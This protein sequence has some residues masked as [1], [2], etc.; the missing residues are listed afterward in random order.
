MIEFPNSTHSKHCNTFTLEFPIIWVSKIPN[1]SLRR[2]PFNICWFPQTG[3]CGPPLIVVTSN[4]STTLFMLLSLK[5][6]K[7]DNYNHG[8]MLFIPYFHNLILH[9]LL[10]FCVGKGSFFPFC[11][12]EYLVTKSIKTQQNKQQ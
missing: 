7:L 2:I 9:E 11:Y 3:Q 8:W 10:C 5:I 1:Q 12:V 6:L 4:I